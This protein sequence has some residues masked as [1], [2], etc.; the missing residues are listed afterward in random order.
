M[1]SY[2]SYC[3]LITSVAQNHSAVMMCTC[4]ASWMQYLYRN[5]GPSIE[6]PS[7]ISLMKALCFVPHA[8][9]T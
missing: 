1:D 8:T 2:Y 9:K 6:H 7:Q 3:I 4:F 5:Y